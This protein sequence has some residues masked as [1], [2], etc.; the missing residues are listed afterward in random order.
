MNAAIGWAAGSDARTGPAGGASS[1]RVVVNSLEY[2]YLALHARKRPFI[3][4]RSWP[5]AGAPVG[6]IDATLLTFEIRSDRPV[7]GEQ[8]RELA[9]ICRPIAGAPDRPVQ[10]TL[11]P[12]LAIVASAAGLPPRAGPGAVGPARRADGRLPSP[13]SSIVGSSRPSA[14]CRAELSTR[15]HGWS[16]RGGAPPDTR[17]LRGN[18]TAF[19]SDARRPPREYWRLLDSTCR[20]GL[21][22]VQMHRIR[23]PASRRIR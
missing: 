7:W 20:P 13:I 12:D 9:F 18:Y 3:E 15:R 16:A 17:E 1:N 11:I 4:F 21:P 10:S 22:A 19:R 5:A 23:P 8:F 14:S 6:E 2:M